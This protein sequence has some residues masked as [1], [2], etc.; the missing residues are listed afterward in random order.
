MDIHRDDKIHECS[1]CNQKFQTR[2]ILRKHM[3]KHDQEYQNQCV[4]KIEGCNQE[5]GSIVF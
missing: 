2:P 4:S 5:V 3:K 1:V